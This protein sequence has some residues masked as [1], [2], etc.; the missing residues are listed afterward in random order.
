MKKGALPNVASAATTPSIVE[1]IEAYLDAIAHA[2]REYPFGP[3]AAVFKIGGKMF[4]LL[5]LDG[6]RL[7]LKLPPSEGLEM[8]AAYPDVVLP[9]YHMNKVHWNT[10]VLGGRPPQDEVIDMIETSLALVTRSLPKRIR[11]ELA[12]T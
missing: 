8:R 1:P 10:I 12:K 3:Q 5:D 2:V 6:A 7:N 9:G 11:D 4:A